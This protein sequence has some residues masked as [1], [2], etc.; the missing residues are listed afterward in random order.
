MLNREFRLKSSKTC[1]LLIF[2]TACGSILIFLNLPLN[3]WIKG[4]GLFIFLAY[5]G[6]MVRCFGLLRSSYSIIGIKRGE[7]DE[8]ILRTNKKLLFAELLGTSTTTHLACVLRFRTATEYW[9]KTCLV[10]PDS[11][12]ADLYRQ[13]LVQIKMH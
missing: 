12:E 11:L 2:T 9:P 6:H 4:G 13:L 10:F 5:I 7:A 1:L 8:W 3:E